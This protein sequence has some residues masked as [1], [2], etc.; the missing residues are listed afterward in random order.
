M[1]LNLKECLEKYYYSMSMEELRSV[2]LV[3]PESK[4]S[5]N[6]TLYLDVIKYTEKC[7][8]SKL[9]DMLHV[10]KP[11]ITSKVNELYAKG[12][13]IKTRSEDDGRV[14]FLSLSNKSDPAYAEE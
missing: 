5:Y 1:S 2:N 3:D 12:Y 14:V 10:T 4:M 13:L 11:T 6:D 9:A 8:V 7:T